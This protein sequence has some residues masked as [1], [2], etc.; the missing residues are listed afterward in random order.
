MSDD[1]PREW[2]LRELA[3]DTGVAERTIRYYISRG[4][5][6]SPLRAGRGAAYGEKHKARI[7]TVRG[8]QAKGLM[9][10]QIEHVLA[11]GAGPSAETALSLRQA[12]VPPRGQM[13]WFEMDGTLAEGQP[14]P[15]ARDSATLSITGPAPGPAPALPE[16]EVWRSY[17]VTRDIRVMLR[18]GAGPWRAKALVA[19]LGRFAAEVKNFV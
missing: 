15:A 3:H 4:L 7:E 16:P 8:L 10:S 11:A 18:A 2:T 13:L 14:G 9:L 1:K 12:E 6:D 19:A 5:V 17:E